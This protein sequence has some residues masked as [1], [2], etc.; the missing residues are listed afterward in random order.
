M[1]FIYFTAILMAELLKLVIC[2]FLV[3]QESGSLPTAVHSLYTTVILNI[4]DTLRVGV[5]SFLYV[6]Q[7]NL[8]YVSSSN[9]DA[10]TYQ[11]HELPS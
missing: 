11:V 5:P 8:L 4:K 3:I 7:N 1:V 6:L 9:L 2:L 10:A